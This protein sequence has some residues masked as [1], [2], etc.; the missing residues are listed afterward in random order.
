MK[1]IILVLGVLVSSSAFSNPTSHSYWEDV[2][3]SS[4]LKASQLKQKSLA[5]SAVST[6]DTLVSR[7][8]SLN[9]VALKEKLFAKSA[10][11][12]RGLKTS[13]LEIELPLPNGQFEKVQLFEYPLLSPEIQASYPDI[14]A[15]RVKGVDHTGIS[16]SIDFTSV[17]FHGMLV[18]P[19][20]DTVYIDPKKGHSSEQ[21]LSFSKS[22]N[23]SHFKNDFNCKVHSEHSLL[24]DPNNRQRDSVGLSSRKLAQQPSLNL[25][26]YKLALAGTAE[27]TASQ[28]GTKASAYASMVTTINRV[29]EIYRRD[30][31]VA[32]QIVSGES[33]IYT[34]A[35]A[36]P[37]TSGNAG[38]LV[39][40]NINN[41]NNQFGAANYD[42]GHVFD[43]S[44]M[45]GLAYVGAA[46]STNYKAGGATGIN[47]PTGE[48]FSIEYVAHE[49]G[50]QLG[51]DHTFNSSIGGCG[52]GNR[53]AGM[54]VEPGSGSSIMSYSGLC[55]AD[56]L[57]FSSD[58]TFHI[59]SI[60]QINDFTR[61]SGGS[62]CG[63]RSST[64]SQDPVVDAGLDMKIPANTPFL[65]AGSAT[66]GS[67][68][69]WDQ[70]DVG[71][72]TSVNI[73]SG[74]NALIRMLLPSPIA[75]RYIP[76]LSDLF[77]GING[78]GEKPPTTSR[79]L[80]FSLVVRNGAGGVG[81][82]EKVVSVTDTGLNFGVLSQSTSQ[83]LSTG[84][85]VDVSWNVAGTNNPPISCNNVD[86]NLLRVDGVKNILLANTAND[87]TEQVVV[88]ANTPVMTGARIMVACSSKDFFQISS[89]S[90]GIIEGVGDVVVPVVT[91]I[92]NSQLSI[93]QGS[94]YQELGA[95]ATDNVDAQVLVQITGSVNTSISGN[96]QVTYSATDAAGN[97]GSAIRNVSVTAP[98]P[99]DT[100]APVITLNGSASVSIV[101][102]SV[103]VDAGATAVDNVDAIVSVLLSNAV[104]TA[105]IGN[106]TVSYT[107]TDSAGNTSVK[108]RIVDVI[109]ETNTP[110]ADTTAP[111]ITVNGELTISLL[112]GESYVEQ[113]A[114]ALDNKDG[115][116]NV[117][118]TGVVNTNQVG[119]NFIVYTAI[120]VAGNSASKTRVVLVSEAASE[121]LEDT[122][123]P[124]ITLVGS[125]TINLIV[126]DTFVDPGYS[127]F[128][129]HDGVLHVVVSGTV[130]T[131]R[132]GTY[133]LT[134]TAKDAANNIT[135]KQ[136]RV[137][138]REP[139]VVVV[140]PNTPTVSVVDTVEP[141]ITL[142]GNSSMTIELGEDYTDPGFAGFDDRDGTLTVQVEGSVDTS[143]AGT[144][145]ITYTVT[146]AAG[147]TTVRSRTIIVAES[148]DSS[149]DKQESASAGSVNFW[150]LSSLLL[151]AGLRR[152]RSN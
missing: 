100:E 132:A 140:T 112:V 116:L 37:Y 59:R 35:A 48:A 38:A 106:Y 135:T 72:S 41:I 101:K 115:V 137:I 142:T 79:N 84:Q 57:Q 88:P 58:A 69:S 87:G 139:V 16:G 136:R 127:G 147:N 123:A 125:D 29:N 113:G 51:A 92:G 144:Y 128:D 53:S 34:D 55:G 10:L 75:N 146:D 20:G 17:G 78:L 31:G 99:A 33:L 44:S 28:G 133:T 42:V 71:S 94:V 7:A 119:A 117:I 56:N 32:L 19:D 23:H 52:G 111:V 6:A 122:V 5:D 118:T 124:I 76:R 63:V 126:G 145:V 26:T 64:G 67:T 70:T 86:I 45:G 143:K 62:S 91:L 104:D 138:V 15:W 49:M 129:A 108:T 40:E 96:Y 25:I 93:A 77:A 152:R 141:V 13:P 149:G 21:Y 130:N 114:T 4:Q 11:S 46:C 39:S 47:N 131:N 60:Q 18:M 107:A 2:R 30:I 97:T 89:G 61:L 85:S 8:L 148:A 98:V 134:Y 66:G 110:P 73:D 150:F 12:A 103:Y 74:N 65:L 9:V 121:I 36:D 50:H 95:T 54:A 102:G 3:Y 120:D 83:T 80:T 81:I 82:D 14:K 43:A 105:V 1:K 24:S 22:Q 90:I 151:L 68:Y 27:Y 109:A